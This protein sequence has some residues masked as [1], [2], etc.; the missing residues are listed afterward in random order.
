MTKTLQEKIARSTMV[1]AE[2]EAAK[3]MSDWNFAQAAAKNYV[4]SEAAQKVAA[5]AL[6]HDVPLTDVEGLYELTDQEALAAVYLFV[7]A[8]HQD[9]F[10]SLLSEAKNLA[11]GLIQ[12]QEQLDRDA[13]NRRHWDQLH[14]WATYPGGYVAD[15][16]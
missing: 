9:R 2:L 12:R 8:F 5:E 4:R 1:T 6:E 15:L 7:S 14:L 13:D 10:A 11:A 3:A 16:A